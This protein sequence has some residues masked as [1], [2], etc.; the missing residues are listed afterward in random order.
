MFR[1]VNAWVTNQAMRG[2]NSATYIKIKV[3]RYRVV[4]RQT[5]MKS[6]GRTI[7][8]GVTVA[9]GIVLMAAVV[10]P[11]MPSV[12]PV[13]EYASVTGVGFDSA[14]ICYSTSGGVCRLE[15]VSASTGQRQGAESLMR[16]AATL[17]EKGWELAAATD[18]SKGNVLYFKRLKSVLNRSDSSSSH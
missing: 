7:R 4:Q 1:W 11:Q 12:G 6:Y 9:A 17:G 16:A 3:P 15:H 18:A 13:W 14:D 8:I 10:R 2:Y 5:G